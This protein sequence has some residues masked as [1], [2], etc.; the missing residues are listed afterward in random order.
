MFFAYAMRLINSSETNSRFLEFPLVAVH[1]KCY[2]ILNSLSTNNHVAKHRWA[3]KCP[4][5]SFEGAKR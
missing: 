5:T 1:A 4:H 3:W 2:L